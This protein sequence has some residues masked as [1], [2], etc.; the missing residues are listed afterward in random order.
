MDRYEPQR[1]KKITYDLNL[2]L[3]QLVRD[4]RVISVT[5]RGFTIVAALAIRGKPVA[6]ADLGAIVLP[7]IEERV[8]VNALKVSI[9][10]LRARLGDPEII[11]YSHARGGYFF[12]SIVRINHPAAAP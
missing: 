8:A 7:G 3:C 6:P 11:Q 2:A 5:E 4:G 1:A 10:R 9:H 12:G